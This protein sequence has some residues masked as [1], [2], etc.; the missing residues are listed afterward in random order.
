MISKL[1]DHTVDEQ[2]IEQSN[3]ISLKNMEVSKRKIG[4]LEDLVQKSMV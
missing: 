1:V 4:N 3:L 2:T